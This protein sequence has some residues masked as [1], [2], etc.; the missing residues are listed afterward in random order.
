METIFTCCAALAGSLLLGVFALSLTR[1]VETDPDN[2]TS[3]T[4]PRVTDTP[5]SRER[6]IMTGKW[7]AG[8]FTLRAILAGVS[9]FGLS[10]LVMAGQ[11][12]ERGCV[13]SAASCGLCTM[14]VMGVFIRA[15]HGAEHDATARLQSTLGTEGTVCLT[16]PAQNS[17]LGK[18]TLPVNGRTMKYAATTSHYALAVGSAVLVVGIEPPDTVD[19]KACDI[20]PDR[21]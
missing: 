6:A 18:V 8:M 13:V 15:M 17:G 16:I 1:Q 3:D 10:G 12:S 14:Y 5:E 2:V 19:V 4:D 21:A 11:L 20:E 9:V 7:F